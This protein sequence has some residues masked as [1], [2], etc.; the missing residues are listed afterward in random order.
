MSHVTTFS[1][2]WAVSSNARD[3]AHMFCN[4]KYTLTKKVYRVHPQTLNSFST[5]NWSNFLQILIKNTKNLPIEVPI[6]GI[7]C[8]KTSNWYLCVIQYA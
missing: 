3:C 2:I 6:G 8:L 1:K 5:K 7:F 4:A